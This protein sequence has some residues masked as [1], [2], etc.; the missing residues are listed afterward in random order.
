MSYAVVK[1]HR[2]GHH[3]RAF[4]ARKSGKAFYLIGEIY[5]YELADHIAEMLNEHPAPAITPVARDTTRYP[6]GKPN[7]VTAIAERKR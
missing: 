1:S 4:V 2:Q 5:S 6:E 3:P 7:I